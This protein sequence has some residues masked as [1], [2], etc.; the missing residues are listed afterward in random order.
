MIRAFRI[1]FSTN[2]ERVAL[3]LGHKGID[4]DWVD[5]DPNDR[6]PV[7][8]ASGQELVP[9]LEVDGQV[10]ADSTAILEYLEKRHPDPPLYPLAPARRAEARIFVDWF[11]RVW[12]RPPNRL[13]DELAKERPD[14]ALA[15]ALAEELAGSR[16][17]FEAML[18]RRDYLLGDFTV[19]DCASFPFLKYG[20]LWREED[21]EP[22]HRI[23]VQHLRFDDRYPRLEAWV[24]RVDQHARA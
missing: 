2:V 13:T 17:L 12:K 1:P 20:L 14:E 5:V 21:D 4:V 19:A 3:A 7:R 23:L 22:F 15:G 18:C 24:R 6:T 16:D 11:N 9:V 8:E 10:V